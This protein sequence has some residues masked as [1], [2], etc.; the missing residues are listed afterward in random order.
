[1][2]QVLKCWGWS[3]GK[4]EKVNGR[5]GANGERKRKGEARERGGRL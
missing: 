1:V 2:K 4:L 3:V 5:G